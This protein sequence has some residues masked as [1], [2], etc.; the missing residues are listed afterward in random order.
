MSNGQ[1]TNIVGVD[2]IIPDPHCMW[3]LTPPEQGEQLS[4]TVEEHKIAC[5]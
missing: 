4:I 2:L 3:D 1:T 5:T